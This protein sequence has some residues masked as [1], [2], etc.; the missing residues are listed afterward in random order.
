MTIK[1]E[2]PPIG[3]HPT[4]GAHTMSTAHETQHKVTTLPEFLEMLV[5]A[6]DGVTSPCMPDAVSV[7]LTGLH[8]VG[9]R[10]CSVRITQASVLTT[11]NTTA[12]SMTTSFTKVSV[13]RNSISRTK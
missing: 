12:R 11:L 9:V 3:E 7:R 8:Q 13:Q 4:D 6:C 2:S 5:E 1:D 10:A